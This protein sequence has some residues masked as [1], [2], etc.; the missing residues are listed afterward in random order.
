MQFKSMVMFKI[1][2]P[3]IAQYKSYEQKK[4]PELTAHEYISIAIA[5]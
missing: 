4:K 1:P 2:K 5:F 3:K